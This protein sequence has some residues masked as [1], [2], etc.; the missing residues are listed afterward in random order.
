MS[1]TTKQWVHGLLAA[2]IGGVASALDSGIA[3]MIIA[4]AQFNLSSG[5]WKTLLTVTVLGILTGIKVSAAYLRQSPLPSD[6]VEV[7]TTESV[8]VTAT[9]KD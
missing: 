6:S 3:L 9:P 5:L 8:T 2:F 7:K 4:P 1:D